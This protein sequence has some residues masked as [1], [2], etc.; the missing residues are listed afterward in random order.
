MSAI[1]LTG[2]TYTV[3]GKLTNNH[4][5]GGVPGYS[6]D[7]MDKDLIGSDDLLGT[8]VTDAK[9]EFE[10][11]FDQSAF[12]NRFIDRTPD[13]YFIASRNGQEVYNSV[14]NP[15]CNVTPASIAEEEIVIS[16]D[17]MPDWT[18]NEVKDV[19]QYKGADWSNEVDRLSG[20]TL[21][22]AQQHAIANPAITF[23]FLMERNMFLEGKSG[24]GGWTE[25][26][27]F[28]PGDA[29]FFS[30]NPWYGS[31]VGFANAYEKVVL[32]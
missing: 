12:G 18:W 5:V 20:Q 29:V 26:G 27:S 22:T 9:G 19:A 25:K 30:G 23:F 8:A 2:T 3:K 13:L 16:T 7:V 14:D 15:I 11:T 21:A 4:V 1:T 32:P 17:F 24:A 31:A 6:I 28:R 10:V